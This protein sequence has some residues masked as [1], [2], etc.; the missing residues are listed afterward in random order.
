MVADRKSL[1][2]AQ[3]KIYRKHHR[4]RDILVYDLPYYDCL[5]I[6]NKSTAKTTLI[7]VYYLWTQ[8]VGERG[9]G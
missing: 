6:I 1:K 9:K 5:K 4:V 8:S 7:L 2:P 3:K